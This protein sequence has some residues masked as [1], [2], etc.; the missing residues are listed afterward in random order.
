MFG[1]SLRYLVAWTLYCFVIVMLASI[2]LPASMLLTRMPLASILGRL[3]IWL[4][5]PF[6]ACLDATRTRFDD[7]DC[8]D[9]RSLGYLV[10]WILGPLDVY[11]RLDAA[12]FHDAA[13]SAAR[14]DLWSLG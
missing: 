2:L 10:A 12:P 11:A 6:D 3:D 5:G 1:R 4:F 13:R 9:V 14:F 7:A 8:S